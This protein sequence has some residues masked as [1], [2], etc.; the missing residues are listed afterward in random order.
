MLKRAHVEEA[1]AAHDCQHNSRHRLQKG[2]KRLA[3]RKERNFEYFCVACA[4]ES[5]DADIQKLTEFRQQLTE[6]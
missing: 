4:L 2:D 1:K 5:I 3:I 6:V